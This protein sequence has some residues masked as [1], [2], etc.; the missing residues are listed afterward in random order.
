[1]R[2]L[3]IAAALLVLLAATA[4]ADILVVI[5]KLDQEMTVAINGVPTYRWAVST[6]SQGRET[7]SGSYRAIRLERVYY[8]KKFDDAPMPNSVFFHGGYAI[9]GTYEVSKLGRPASHGCVRLHR[10]NAET[11]FNLVHAQGMAATRIVVRDEPNGGA[12]ARYDRQDRQDRFAYRDRQE[13]YERSLAA[14]R[15]D[16]EE[17]RPRGYQEYGPYDA[18]R[19]REPPRRVYWN[20][21]GWRY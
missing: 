16:R 11:L 7:P 17:Y 21:S 14:R 12:M 15:S 6:G 9:H 8:S 1:M 4:R 13:R 19:Y 5:S 20:D 3:G 2:R 10:A 18:P